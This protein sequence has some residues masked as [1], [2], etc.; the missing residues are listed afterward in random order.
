MHRESFGVLGSYYRCYTFCQSDGPESGFVDLCQQTSQFYTNDQQ[1]ETV[2]DNLLF[3]CSL[4]ALHVSR[5]I[6][7]HHQEHLNCS[8]SFWFIYVCR[9]L[10]SSAADNDTRE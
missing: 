3:P 1:D 7:A 8:Y 9:R 5:D 4:T 2:W 10:L 6:I